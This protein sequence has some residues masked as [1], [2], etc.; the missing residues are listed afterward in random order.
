VTGTN[1]YA[2]G[3]VPF[4]SSN[5]WWNT[6]ANWQAY[7]IV[8]LSCEGYPDAYDTTKKSV[9]ARQAM[10]TYLDL[11]GRIFASHWHNFWIQMAV[12]LPAPST[13]PTLKTVA[14]FIDP[15]QYT[16]YSNDTTTDEATINMSFAKGQA[17]QQWLANN[18]GLN[19]NSKLPINFTRV[20]LSRMN[21]NVTP[22]KANPD[23]SIATNW[24][25]L[26]RSNGAL[27]TRLANPPS[28]YFSF[29][30]PLSQPRESQCGQMVFTDLHVSGGPNGDHSAA[31][32]MYAFP[33]GCTTSGLTPQE[34]A[35]IFLLFD[36]T[37]CLS[38]VPG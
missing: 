17:L 18:S 32:T 22:A 38:P 13:E 1:Q 9:Q 2:T 35:L 31:G 14:G 29:Y 10:Q 3:A 21:N 20:T 7:D 26:T 15:T 37:S 27:D 5:P 19:A 11:G 4:T 28:Q 23:P 12:P 24:L 8:M 25:D 16:G 34:K 30:T 33:K 6:A 36:L